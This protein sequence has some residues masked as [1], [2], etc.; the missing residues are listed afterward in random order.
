MPALFS[1]AW[2][3]SKAK[4]SARA[5]ESCGWES[6]GKRC[7]SAQMQLLQC[8]RATPRNKLACWDRVRLRVPFATQR[9]NRRPRQRRLEPTSFCSSA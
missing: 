2:H 8:R 4:H 6:L 9:L 1:K 5:W 3:G 7:G